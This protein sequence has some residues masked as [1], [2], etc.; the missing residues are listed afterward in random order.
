MFV[1]GLIVI[2]ISINFVIS[3]IS[4]IHLLS[5]PE[6]VSNS[7]LVIYE[8]E[9]TKSELKEAEITTSSFIITGDEGYLTPFAN[10]VNN[11]KGHLNR[12]LKSSEI[13]SNIKPKVIELSTKIDDMINDFNDGIEARR[14]EDYTAAQEYISSDDIKIDRKSVV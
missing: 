7:H 11:I 6:Y 8:L 1:F 10:S 3:I 12:V 2:L 13:N 9:A 4:T 5:V 14:D